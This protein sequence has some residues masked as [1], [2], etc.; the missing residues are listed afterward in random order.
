LTSH[1]LVVI[2]LLRYTDP[3]DHDTL[4]PIPIYECVCGCE[5]VR[6]PLSIVAVGRSPVG[7]LVIYASSVAA[8][9][10]TENDKTE[11][12]GLYPYAEYADP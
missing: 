5:K 10:P 1:T 4:S 7:V 9:S 12:A 2:F 6:T 8:W 3:P 11:A